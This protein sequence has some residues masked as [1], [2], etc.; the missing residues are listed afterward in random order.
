M[1]EVLCYSYV[2]DDENK[3]ERRAVSSSRPLA[4]GGQVGTLCGALCFLAVPRCGVQLVLWP[5]PVQLAN[6]QH[7]RFLTLW[8]RSEKPGLSNSPRTTGG[9]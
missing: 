9:V 3:T 6:D 5:V 1:R 2:S 4:G 8:L 7:L